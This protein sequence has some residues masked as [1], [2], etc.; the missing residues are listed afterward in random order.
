MD[1]D[2][3]TQVGSTSSS[4]GMGGLSGI[5]GTSASTSASSGASDGQG[6]RDMARNLA[7]DAK[8][9]ASEQVRSS[10]DKGRSR[11]ADTLHEVARTL[12]GTGDQGDNPAAPYMNRAGEQVRRAADYLQNADLKQMM[13]STEQF[14]RREPALFLGG[15]F[16]IGVLAARFLKS[17]RTETERFG[18]D[19]GFDRMVDRERSLSSYREPNGYS[20]ASSSYSSGSPILNESNTIGKEHDWAGSTG[21][22][23][24]S[25]SG[26]GPT[27]RS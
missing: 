11:A 23:H 6:V 19:G 1:T 13:S 9:K 14:A 22:S 2:N 24:S 27:D 20:A 21:T 17:T 18:D 12:M 10:V 16:A 4:G 15:A 7:S 5:D 26:I 8:Q 25:N 3:S